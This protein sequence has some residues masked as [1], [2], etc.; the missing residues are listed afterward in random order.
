MQHEEFE[1]CFSV[2]FHCGSKFSAMFLYIKD[3]GNSKMISMESSK[4]CI[5]YCI[6]LVTGAKRKIS[7]TFSLS[8]RL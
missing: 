4:Y 3:N 7:G 1:N 6:V 8:S 5:G 2:I